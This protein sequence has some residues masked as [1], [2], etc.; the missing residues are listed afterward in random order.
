MLARVT[1][2]AQETFLSASSG[3][4]PFV[5]QLFFLVC[6]FNVRDQETGFLFLSLSLFF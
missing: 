5:F 2:F 6:L 3:L 1:L 4:I